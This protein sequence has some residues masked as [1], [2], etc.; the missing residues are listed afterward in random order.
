MPFTPPNQEHQ[1]Q[2][3]DAKRLLANPDHHF[4]PRKARKMLAAFL[5]E[6]NRLH[7]HLLSQHTKE[8]S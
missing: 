7:H 8:Q 1:E 4:D 6:Y 2:M 5:V 3:D